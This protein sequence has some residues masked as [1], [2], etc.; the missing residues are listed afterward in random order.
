VVLLLIAHR[1]HLRGPSWISFGLQFLGALYVVLTVMSVRTQLIRRRVLNEM[2]RLWSNTGPVRMQVSD[3]GLLVETAR[4]SSLLPWKSFLRLSDRDDLFLLYEGTY[5]V[6]T[7]PKRGFASDADVERFMQMA[8]RH[9]DDAPRA[10][11]RAF[12]VIQKS[13]E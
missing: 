3:E 9:I 7:V 5:N 13:G 12:P 8:R 11:P 4:G 6:F 2:W 1:Q 10:E